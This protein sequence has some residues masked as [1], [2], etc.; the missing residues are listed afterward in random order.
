M[1]LTLFIHLSVTLEKSVLEDE[2][3][4]SPFKKSETMETGNKVENKIFFFLRNVSSILC[5]VSIRNV[6]K[7]LKITKNQLQ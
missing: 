6:D 3:L 4:E 5:S 7:I 2:C 1:Y